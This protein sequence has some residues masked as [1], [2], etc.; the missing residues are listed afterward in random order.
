MA[1]ERKVLERRVFP[2]R[3]EPDAHDACKVDEDHHPVQTEVEP[4]VHRMHQARRV[5]WRTIEFRPLASYFIR[6]IAGSWLANA[7]RLRTGLRGLSVL[8]SAA[9]APLPPLAAPALAAV[10]APVA[11]R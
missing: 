2:G 7:A 3:V 11:V 5:F 6:R 8:E 10:P 4:V 1:P 9:L